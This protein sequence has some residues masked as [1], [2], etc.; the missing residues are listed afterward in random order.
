M[1]L[2]HYDGS[3]AIAP[4][5]RMVS[6]RL[7]LAAAICVLASVLAANAQTSQGQA[8]T[9]SSSLKET[10]WNLVELEGDAVT[11][12]SP[13]SDPYIYLHEDSDK[14]TG[15]GGCNRFFGSF[16]LD[17]NSLEFHS[18]AQ[19]LMACPGNAGSH[20]PTLLEALKLTTSYRITADELELR[21]GERV[22]ARFRGEK[23]R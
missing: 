4:E 9:P 20:E 19:T 17:G 2:V 10:Q 3:G 21:V 12:A 5:R 8:S 15:S 22:L 18:V 6:R 7:L 16:D 23:K 11:A 1:W 14:L 13:E